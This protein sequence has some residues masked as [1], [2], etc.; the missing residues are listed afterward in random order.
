MTTDP[1]DTALAG[2]ERWTATTKRK[3]SAESVGEVETLLDLMRDYLD[4]E[5]PA[6]LGEGDLR[7]LL[8]S[9]YPRKMTVFDAADTEGTVPAVRDF[10]AYL[11][12]RGEMPEGT[13]R[14][15]ERELD[16]VAPRFT[17]AMMDP[18]NIRTR[19]MC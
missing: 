1:F 4:I 16:E 3:L 15:L 6:D 17:E 7:E 8:L 12:E 10:L 19:R 14:A 9:V 13:V 11:A 18:S 5:G 2:F